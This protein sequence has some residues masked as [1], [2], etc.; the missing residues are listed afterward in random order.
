MYGTNVRPKKNTV[1]CTTFNCF[2]GN[3]TH[4]SAAVKYME[5]EVRKMRLR[6]YL[7]TKWQSTQRSTVI[8][9][10]RIEINFVLIHPLSS[11]L[12][13]AVA[14]WVS[15]EIHFRWNG[16]QFA[17]GSRSHRMC[18]ACVILRIKT[19]SSN[20]L[21]IH[22]VSPLQSLFVWLYTHTHTQINWFFHIR[23]A[24]SQTVNRK[25]SLTRCVR[26]VR[27]ADLIQQIIRR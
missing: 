21:N 20:Y 13:R 26:F 27:V 23:C 4:N 3:D 14:Q 1:N 8:R 15:H 11:S 5:C 12:D 25:N 7:H 17:I 18:V 22:N 9:S 6:T 2:C 10:K 19:M 24:A 16:V